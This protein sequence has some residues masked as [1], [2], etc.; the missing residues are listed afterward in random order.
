MPRGNGLKQR[1]LAAQAASD[2]EDTNEQCSEWAY[3]GECEKN[4]GFMEAS[5]K[6]SCGHCG[7]HKA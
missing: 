6:K 2:C 7:N 4:P 5:C 1:K 3:F